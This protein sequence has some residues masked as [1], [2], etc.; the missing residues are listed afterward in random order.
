MLLLQYYFMCEG[1]S[2]SIHNAAAFV[3][4]LAALSFSCASLGIISLLSLLCK[5][6]VARSVPLS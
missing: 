2:I 1:E 3:F 4:L 5:F 6:E